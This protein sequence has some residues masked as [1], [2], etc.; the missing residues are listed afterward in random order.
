MRRNRHFTGLL[1]YTRKQIQ[2]ERR[3]FIFVNRRSGRRTV[4]LHLMLSN[5]SVLF[6]ETFHSLKIRNYRIFFIGQCISLTGTWMQRT[7]EIWLVYTL[8]KSPFLVGLFGVC[9]FIPMLLLSLFVGALID[10]LPKRKLLL[11]T[12]FLFM[13]QAA[14][15]TILTYTHLIRYWHLLVLAVVF[16]IAQTIDLPTRQA[17]FY[18]MVGKKEIANAVSL[19][20]A[21]TNLAK[22]TG[23]AISGVVLASFGTVFCFFVNAVSFVAVIVSIL[24]IH[25]DEIVHRDAAG[26]NVIR[27]VGK[28]LRYIT[29]NETLLLNTLI[30]GIVSTLAMNNEVIVPIFAGSVLHL[31]AGGY[32]GLMTAA[33]LGAFCGALT[34][35][36]LSRNG[37]EK[38]YLLLGSI[39]TSALQIATILTRSYAVSLILLVCIGFLNL[40]I[41]PTVNSIYQLYSNDEYRGRVLSVYSL[42]NQGSTPLGNFLVGAVMEGFGGASGFVFCG[43]STLLLLAPVCVWKRGALAEWFAKKP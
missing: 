19:N 37:V 3:I 39:A 36:F 40:I 32:T 35:A 38:K 31:G 1:W 14:V 12:E 8:T 17:F 30:F 9:Q 28:G 24:L 20:S 29:E 21:I 15:M 23:P 26:G 7:A 18:E 34:I 43:A 5:A 41:I 22:M 33:G 10:R 16:G 2:N 4:L 13:A 27:D 25:V 11:F 6:S 42:L